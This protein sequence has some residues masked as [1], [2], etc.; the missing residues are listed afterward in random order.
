[1]MPE[2]DLETYAELS[3]A[4]AV[5][6]PARERLL[7]EHGLDEERWNAIEE[8]WDAALSR[9]EEQHGDADGVPPLVARFAELFRRAQQ[10]QNQGQEIVPFEL[11]VRITRAVSRGRDVAQVL[12]RHRISLAA[13]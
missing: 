9:A 10:A 11:Y 1:A 5:A 2:L 13:Y 3:A 4:L 7:A 8:A 6:G 12:E